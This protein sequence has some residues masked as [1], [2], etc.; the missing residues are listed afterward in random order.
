[1]G[2]SFSQN[3]HE[4]LAV[5]DAALPRNIIGYLVQL[6]LSPFRADPFTVLPYDNPKEIAKCGPDIGKRSF[7]PIKLPEREGLRPEILKFVA[8]NRQVDQFTGDDMHK[9]SP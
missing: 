3:Y 5:A 9:A 6:S 2:A 4:W 1:M 7:L 8:P